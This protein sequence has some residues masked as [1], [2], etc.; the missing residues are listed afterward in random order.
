MMADDCCQSQQLCS[1]DHWCW[2]TDDR[3]ERRRSFTEMSFLHKNALKN[4][5]TTD[6]EQTYIVK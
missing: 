4:I 5:L 6:I 3:D 1:Y 2:D